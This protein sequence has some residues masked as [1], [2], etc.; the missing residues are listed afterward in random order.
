[1]GWFKPKIL[2]IITTRKC[3]AE[4]SNCC[5]KCSP[6]EKRQ[7]TTPQI[8]N[9]INQIKDVPSIE[10][11]ALTG[12]ECFLLGQD[13]SLVIQEIK[14]NNLHS[15]CVTNA[16]WASSEEIAFQKLKKLANAGLTEINY[17]T[18]PNHQKFVPAENII[19]AVKASIKLEILTG[20][21]IEAGLGDAVSYDWVYKDKTIEAAFG[22]NKLHITNSAWM[23]HGSEILSY[24]YDGRS[25]KK[26]CQ[27]NS[28]PSP[29]HNRFN[30]DNMTGCANLLHGINVNTEMEVS[31]CC[32]LTQD[33]LSALKIGSLKESSLKNLIE[34]TS[35]DLLQ[36]WLHVDGP[37]KILQFVKE[38][39]PSFK[40][41]KDTYHICHTCLFLYKNKQARRVIEK[42]Y[43]EIEEDVLDRYYLE[44]I[45]KEF[46]AK[47][48]S[49][50]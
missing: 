29:K 23:P 50:S 35:G 49:K 36:M 10:L 19:N 13:L 11:V 18:G 33:Y 40:I 41:P 37:E 5:F 25:V 43:K 2:S 26:T 24:C 34:S 20:I 14:K 45:S 7:L 27:H 9:I 17:S 48:A 8:L 6:R 3:T 44:I 1:M 39:S 47:T 21:N 38:K 30:P 4:C 31:T 46:T 32:G 42:Y 16:Y 28:C 12:G 15:R 22:K